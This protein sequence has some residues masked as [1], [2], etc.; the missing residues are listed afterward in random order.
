[1]P[2]PLGISS[3]TLLERWVWILETLAWGLCTHSSGCPPQ[4]PLMVSNTS[5]EWHHITSY[6][7][8]T[9]NT[10]GRILKPSKNS[11]ISPTV[12]QRWPK[13]YNQR[14]LK[15]THRQRALFFICYIGLTL[16][17]ESFSFNQIHD[18]I[19]TKALEDDNRAVTSAAWMTPSARIYR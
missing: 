18:K 15:V 13:L 11:W 2:L 8:V 7:T 14:C 4:L 16:K 19:Y 5:S 9:S 6:L 1:M 12:F 10:N 3:D 17:I